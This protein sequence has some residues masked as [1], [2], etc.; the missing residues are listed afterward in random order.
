[1]QTEALK[2]E[3][4]LKDIPLNFFIGLMERGMIPDFAIRYGI[5]KLLRERLK[6]SARAIQLAG[7]HDHYLASYTDQLNRSPLAIMTKEANEQHYEVPTEYF[8]HAL[9]VH[10]KYSCCYFDETTK[11]LGEAEQKALDLSIEFAGVENG[12]SILEF[13]CG[14]GSLSLELARRFPDSKIISVSNSRTQKK[15]IDDMAK[16]RGLKNLE[17]RTLNLALEENYDF[18]ELKFDRIMTIEMMEHLRNYKRFFKLVEPLLKPEGKMFIHIFTHKDTPYFYETEGA[19]NWMGKYF[20]SGGQMP[21]VHL[22]ENVQSQFKV[23]NLR[24]WNGNHY[25]KTL[26]AWLE[27]GDLHFD[28]INPHFEKTY[29]KKNAWLW[30]NR[31]RV[32]YMA[33]S[34]LFKYNNGEEWFVTHYLLSKRPGSEPRGEQ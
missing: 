1:M 11:T 28:K 19:D 3:S 17:V 30:F 31:W 20:F 16:S 18:G 14:W 6:E 34:E 8:D 12:M 23:E 22:F 29:G 33:C 24:T 2:T 4:S 15:Y 32:F 10:K 27:Q 13:G 21:S 5:K 9:G 26:E 25:S 7:S